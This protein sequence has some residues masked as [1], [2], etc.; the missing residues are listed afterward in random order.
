MI[1]QNRGRAPARAR[2]GT[3]RSG[4]PASSRSRT[5]VTG[6]PLW[7][8]TDIELAQRQGTNVLLTGPDDRCDAI[9]E[10]LRPG[11]TEPIVTWRPGEKLILPPE[12]TVGTL[13]IRELGDLAPAQQE[14]LFGWL[15]RAATTKVISTARGSLLPRI[16][17]G[18]FRDALYYRLN[19]VC[20]E[21]SPQRS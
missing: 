17:T 1:S 20:I 13:I 6:L 8:S 19:T 4:V 9:I 12:Q 11:L 14:R 2:A 18:A 16:R 5:G 10:R 3:H 7:P 15:G 21:M